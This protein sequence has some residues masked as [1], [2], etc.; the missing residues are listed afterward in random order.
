MRRLIAV[1]HWMFQWEVEKKEREQ[2]LY[3]FL[4]RNKERPPKADPLTTAFGGDDGKGTHQKEHRKTVL[5]LNSNWKQN[6]EL[7]HHHYKKWYNK[8]SIYLRTFQFVNGC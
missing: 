3:Y 7:R 6:R 4:S 2:L 5:K 1:S 8:N